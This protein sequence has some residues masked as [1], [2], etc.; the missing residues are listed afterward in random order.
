MMAAGSLEKLSSF[1]AVE[2]GMQLFF[3]MI[4]VRYLSSADLP[5]LLALKGRVAGA[6]G[7]LILRRV[8]PE[9]LEV[10]R[11]TRL[12]TLFEI[13]GFSPRGNQ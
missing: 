3:D 6:G 2:P 8:H 9:I 4:D 13:E 10:L 12:D 5:K 7:R 11:I 1:I